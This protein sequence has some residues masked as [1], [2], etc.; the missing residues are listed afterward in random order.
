MFGT[1]DLGSNF[2]L[3]SHLELRYINGV[4]RLLKNI[5]YPPKTDK[6]AVRAHKESLSF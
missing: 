1:S 6:P 3:L 4:F 2:W 5:L